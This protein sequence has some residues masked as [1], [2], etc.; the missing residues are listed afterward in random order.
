M[1]YSETDIKHYLYASETDLYPPEIITNMRQ[2]VEML[3]K[4]I[5][6]ND[7]IFL[8]ID[9]DCD[10]FTSS[11]LFLNYLNCLFPNYV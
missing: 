2:G 10:G 6:N 1:N 9:D 7:K 4:H 5:K 11:A 8:Q 3:V